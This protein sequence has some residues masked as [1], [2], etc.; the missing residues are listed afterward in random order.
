MSDKK[1]GA[2][3]S[4]KISV[5]TTE[6]DKLEAQLKRI[7]GLMNDA[8][9]NQS[10]EFKIDIASGSAEFTGITTIMSKD[11]AFVNDAF[12]D[13]EVLQ[14]VARKAANRESSKIMWRVGGDGIYVWW[15]SIAWFRRVHW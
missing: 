15:F 13:K 2:E 1:E 12:I 9:L 5:D 14:D 11:K 7:F 3:F 6:L 4:I 8:G 10:A